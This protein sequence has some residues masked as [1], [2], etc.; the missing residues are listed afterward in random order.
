MYSLR[1]Q[2]LEIVSGYAEAPD[3][4]HKGQ[5]PDERERHFCAKG[6]V[7]VRILSDQPYECVDGDYGG[8]QSGNQESPSGKAALLQQLYEPQMFC[9]QEGRGVGDVLVG[10]DGNA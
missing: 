7:I 1:L 10:V 9:A 4:E 6:H 5:N 8:H 3:T 2:V